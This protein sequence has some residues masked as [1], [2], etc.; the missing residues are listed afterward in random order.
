MAVR[1]L[2]TVV[3]PPS[4]PGRRRGLQALTLGVAVMV[5]CI[6]GLGA[7][8]RVAGPAAVG[9]ALLQWPERRALRG[10]GLSLL[11]ALMLA[12][13]ALA[14]G[15]YGSLRALPTR[16]AR[17]FHAGAQYPLPPA[18]MEKTR[19]ALGPRRFELVGFLPHVAASP[20][21][22]LYRISCYEPLAPAA[23]VELS[24]ALEGRPSRGR[25]LAKL[26]PQQFAALYDLTGV[27]R[28][29]VAGENRQIELVSNND[30]LPRAY[31]APVLAHVDRSTALEHVRQLDFDF[32]SGVLVEPGAPSTTVTGVVPARVT[33]YD[34]ERVV[35]Q[36]EA[37]GRGLLVL[38][39]TFFPGWEAR[40]DGE[41]AEIWRANG[42]HR[43]VA[44]GPGRHEVV[45]EYRPASFRSGAALS[46]ASA[47]AIAAVGAASARA[48]VRARPRGS[49]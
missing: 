21:D 44:I 18:A 13:L 36:A 17:A 26:D 9:L 19:E 45:F 40:V 29:L 2:D 37:N 39:D 32:R 4:S 12:D 43:A 5:A 49:G 7:A 38:T 3:R 11:A 27:A 47:L 30:A 15:T 20:S 41:P 1:G 28:L 34:A 6:T 8:W 25:A 24:E 46:I 35:I 31:V 48:R 23:W 33:G 22:G 14:T 10:A 42:L 16:L